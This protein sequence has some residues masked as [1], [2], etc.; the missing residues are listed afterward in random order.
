MADHTKGQLAYS[1]EGDGSA[2]VIGQ[3]GDD[4]TSVCSV[5]VLTINH[6]SVE[7]AR[8]NARRIVGCW[9]ACIDVPTETLENFP[10]PFSRLREE[11]DRLQAM[12]VEVL[13]RYRFDGVPN[14]S[15]QTVDAAQALI[16]EISGS[17][18]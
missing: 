15:R 6:R 10:A 5:A 2:R 14:D 4:A 9:N 16:S 11:R 3:I 8:A 17:T 1:F 18:S 13:V 7:E 12:L